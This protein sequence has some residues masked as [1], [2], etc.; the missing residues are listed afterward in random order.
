[1]CATCRPA[2]LWSPSFPPSG[3]APPLH[4]CFD[5][6]Q[7]NQSSLYVSWYA[8]YTRKSSVWHQT[9]ERGP[10]GKRRS[11]YRRDWADHVGSTSCSETSLDPQNW[12]ERAFR[13]YLVKKQWKWED[14]S[15]FCFASLIAVSTRAVHF[16]FLTYWAASLGLEL[17]V[18]LTHGLLWWL[19]Q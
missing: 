6:K 11:P 15:A 4:C 19:S 18:G 5:P 2:A 13:M 8:C 12:R 10:P 9:A 7:S 1:M 17:A 14:I 3:L 16:S